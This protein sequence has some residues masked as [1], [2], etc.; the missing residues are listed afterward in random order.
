VRVDFGITD[1][2]L[3]RFQRFAG[4]TEDESAVDGDAKLMAFLVNSR[5]TSTRRPFLMLCRICWLPLS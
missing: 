2:F 4:Q 5:A 3:D 1:G